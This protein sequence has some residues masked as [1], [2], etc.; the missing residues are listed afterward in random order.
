[1]KT[2]GVRSGQL[3]VIYAR[4]S[5]GHGVD[6][7]GQILKRKWG[8]HLCGCL[9]HVLEHLSGCIRHPDTQRRLE[10]GP[11]AVLKLEGALVV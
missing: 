10:L 2:R 1:M 3:K 7:Y 9:I 6:K 5:G 11:V 4:K 8:T